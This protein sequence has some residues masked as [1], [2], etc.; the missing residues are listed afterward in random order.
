M[1]ALKII[2]RIFVYACLALV[3]LF[4]V[5][6]MVSLVA[7]TLIMAGKVVLWVLGGTFVS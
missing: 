2:G 3:L 7:A 4:I 5:F 1:D 6:L